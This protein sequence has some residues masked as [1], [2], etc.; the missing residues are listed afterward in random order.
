LTGVKGTF[1]VA[2]RARPGSAVR[3]VTPELG[4]TDPP[5]VLR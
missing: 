1:R 5:L 4:D 2:V 3:I